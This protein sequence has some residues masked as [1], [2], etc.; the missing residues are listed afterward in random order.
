MLSDRKH[1]QGLPTPRPGKPKEDSG[2]YLVAV[3]VGAQKWQGLWEK[4]E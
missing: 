1:Q 2:R 3:L 4:E